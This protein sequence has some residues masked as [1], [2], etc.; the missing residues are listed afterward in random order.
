MNIFFDVDYTILGADGSLR[1][2]TREIFLKLTQ[3]K[4]VLYVWSGMGI[5]TQDVQRHGLDTLVT[6]VF[7]KPLEDF[8][9]GLRSLGIQVRP[10]LVIDDYPEIVSALGGILVK[11]YYFA[12]SHDREME[13][14]YSIITDYA[15]M[16]RSDDP[17]FRLRQKA[18]N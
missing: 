9:N 10:D 3:E 12:S 2:G 13:R 11:P 5:R 1:P 17:A 14:I 15:R 4:H 16:G 18:S 8:E 6:G 7:Q